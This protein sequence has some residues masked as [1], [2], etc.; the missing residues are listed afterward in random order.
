MY[1]AANE[2][3]NCW[4]GSFD[5]L[6]ERPIQSSQYKCTLSWLLDGV[7]LS[8]T[9]SWSGTLQKGTV[10]IIVS[11]LRLSHPSSINAVR[12]AAVRKCERSARA[13]ACPLRICSMVWGINSCSKVFI[14]RYR[15]L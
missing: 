12:D 13:Q 11:A 9:D 14:S 10:N 3:Q 4:D 8:D 2:Y 5:E 15:S 6:G 7:F 1:S